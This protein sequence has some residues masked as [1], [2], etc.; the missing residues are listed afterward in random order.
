MVS[1]ASSYGGIELT[2]IKRP[3]SVNLHVLI[4]IHAFVHKRHTSVS[5]IHYGIMF[6]P[7]TVY[8]KRLCN[9]K[10]DKIFPMKNIDN[11]LLL[12]RK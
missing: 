12:K 3:L 10:A 2:L 7:S 1:P 8:D 11:S 4:N 5:T 6:D 9:R